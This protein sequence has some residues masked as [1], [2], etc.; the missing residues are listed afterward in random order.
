MK[1]F[2]QITEE[3]KKLFHQKAEKIEFSIGQVFCDF[4]SLPKGLL[5]ITK[6]ELRLIYKDKSKELS[7]IKVHNERPIW[8]KKGGN[9]KNEIL[10]MAD[11]A[12]RCWVVAFATISKKA[13]VFTDLMHSKIY[14]DESQLP[15][16]PPAEAE[17]VLLRDASYNVIKEEDWEWKLGQL[18]PDHL[19][20]VAEAFE[21]RSFNT[22]AT[23]ATGPPSVFCP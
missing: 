17:W 11:A 13:Y 23:A 22:P 15:A 5:H 3:L 6:G 14:D 21:D 9:G 19:D 4:D 20:D 10:F 18:T 12:K 8:K 16:L 1:R 7:T 2:D